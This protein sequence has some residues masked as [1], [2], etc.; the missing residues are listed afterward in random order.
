MILLIAPVLLG[1]VD[2]G[3]LDGF[4]A[5]Y[6]SVKVDVDF[7][8]R[9]GF[10]PTEGWS[11]AMSGDL[12]EFR[13]RTEKRIIGRWSCD[14]RAE[15]HGFSSPP[16]VIEAGKVNFNKL[17]E[18]DVPELHPSGMMRSKAILPFV[19]R[20]EVVFDGEVNAGHHDEDWEQGRSINVW[21][22]GGLGYAALTKGPFLWWTGD[23]F[24]RILRTRLPGISPERRRSVR[25]GRVT[26][27]EV[28][29]FT[30]DASHWFQVEV[31]YDPSVGY[32]PRHARK[33]SFSSKTVTTINDFFLIEAKS[34]AGGGFFP[35]EWVNSRKLVKDFAKNHSEYRAGDEIIPETANV[36]VGHFKAT[37]IKD[38][39]SPVALTDLKHVTSISAAGGRV[40]VSPGTATLTLDAIKSRMGRKLETPPAKPLPTLDFAELQEF[41][42]KPR[43][44]RTYLITSVVVALLA[45]AG[46]L[47]ILGRR[48][49]FASGSPLL[50]ALAAHGLGCARPE[51]PLVRVSGT[52]AQPA[53]LYDVQSPVIDN[54]LVVRNDGNVPLRVNR[55]D[56]GCSC[57]YV[58]QTGLP[59]ELPP[60]ES[61]R[62]D[63]KVSTGRSSTPQALPFTLVCDQG[64]FTVT[65]RL[66][67]LSR[68]QFHPESPS[69]FALGENQEW[70]FELVRRSVFPADQPRPETHLRSGP[71]A[72]V[73][74]GETRTGTV[75]EAPQFVYED[76]TYHV[77][78]LDKTL[79]LR[80]SALPLLDGEGRVLAEVPILWQRETFLSPSPDR[81]LL[82]R[83]AVRVFL[84]CSDDAVE[85][86]RVR[87]CPK[88]VTAVISSP[89]EV[90][91][92][93]VEGSK[94]VVNGMVEVETTATEHPPLRIPVVR[95]EPMDEAA[96]RE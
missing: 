25:G 81:V 29:R 9:Y 30:Q 96:A 6:A 87:S 77:T 24:P 65:A 64:S 2:P 11:N 35:T 46:L 1:Q 17:K 26:S 12:S 61:L 47:A 75:T 16:D 28:Y 74:E 66:L 88:A 55:V 76:V 93:P 23:A 18:E 72:L 95:A 85:L 31:A 13:E 45:G 54:A 40:P 71:E 60:G 38:R 56:G 33:I 63:V 36:E 70:S 15:Y 92:K 82:G 22:D 62:F 5:N 3:P 91:I 51:V 7:E 20:T 94:E 69:R 43:S 48:K 57:R 68:H 19:P 67:A 34:C 8:Y 78:L 83:M 49:R 90:T 50:I 32:L 79:G 59:A 53:A 42:P 89:R 27:E 10:V 73:V 84:R 14:G 58:V 86:T 37:R 21:T 44:S 41:A 4:L 39:A 80:K 52:F